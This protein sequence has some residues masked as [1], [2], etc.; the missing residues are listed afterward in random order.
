MSFIYPTCPTG[1]ES[2]VPEVD[3]DTCAPKISF[4][5]IEHIY[6]AA[7]DAAA[8]TDVEDLS[9]WT[10]RISEDGVDPDAIRDLHVMADL[11][12]ATADEIVITLGRKIYSPAT[13]IINVTI[14]DISDENYEF[15]RATSCNTSYRVWFATESH[16]YGGNDGI[17]ANINLRPVI[18]TGQKSINKLMG[19]VQWE[20]QFSP[21]RHTNPFATV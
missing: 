17:L 18:E 20:H 9:E 8:F 10:T 3:F 14:D 19:T 1:C 2:L 16:I 12:A 21:E 5:E 7:G 4:G 11:P 6:V 15:A 13:H